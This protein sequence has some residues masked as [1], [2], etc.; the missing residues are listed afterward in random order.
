MYSAMHNK[1]KNVLILRHSP[2]VAVL[3][4]ICLLKPTQVS[5][6]KISRSTHLPLG[7]DFPWGTI[8]QNSLL[9][10]LQVYC[11]HFILLFMCSLFPKSCHED[12]DWSSTRLSMPFL[13]HVLTA[14]Q[15]SM[16]SAYICSL[17]IRNSQET[18][19]I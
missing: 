10:I 6:L 12:F 11:D 3:R 5:S 18:L 17:R 15:F 9:C 16:I 13:P 4:S 19:K 8:S 7:K 1:A 14:D 2:S